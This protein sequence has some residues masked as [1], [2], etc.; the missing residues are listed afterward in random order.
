MPRLCEPCASPD[1]HS[2]RRSPAGR[3][4]C[5]TGRLR[6]QHRNDRWPGH[7]TCLE[8]EGTERICAVLRTHSPGIARQ[9]PDAQEPGGR[10]WSE[11]R[12]RSNSNLRA[13][14]VRERKHDAIT[15]STPMLP[16]KSKH[17]T[18]SLRASVVAP[19]LTPVAHT[20]GSPSTLQALRL[21][22]HASSSRP[23][24]SP[25]HSRCSGFI[26]HARRQSTDSSSHSST[27]PAASAISRENDASAR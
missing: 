25:I 14:T 7:T 6:E 19:H 23:T 5:P 9:K 18:R 4:A 26:A 11:H 3:N 13:A 2:S 17:A 10:G 15:R 12:E 24:I 27:G 20:P 22:P 8:A 21:E 1:R 16:L